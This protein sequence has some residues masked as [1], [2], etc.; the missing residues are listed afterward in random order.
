M[1]KNVKYKSAFNE[2]KQVIDINSVIPENREAYT[3]PGCGNELIA[4]LGKKNIKHFRHK[5]ICDCNLETHLHNVAKHYFFERYNKALKNKEPVPLIQAQKLVCSAYKKVNGGVCDFGE[6][7][8]THDLTKF[9]TA[10]SLEKQHDGFVADVLLTTP[11]G[12][13]L[14]VEIAVTHKCEPKKISSGNRIIEFR[15]ESEA[16]LKLL[17]MP[18][19][20]TKQNNKIR[21]YNFQNPKPGQADCGGQCNEWQHSAILLHASGKL[22]YSL[23]SPKGALSLPNRKG[24]Q[25]YQ[26]LDKGLIIEMDRTIPGKEYMGI[27]RYALSQNLKLLTCAVCKHRRMAKW[28]NTGFWCTKVK[29]D[30]PVNAAAECGGY[31]PF[32]TVKEM[33]WYLDKGL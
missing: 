30:V 7:Q 26:L 9:F 31:T 6:T 15:L 32:K 16:D 29:T 3:C 12:D 18:L 27:A 19:D 23:L 11:K 5:E 25:T 2:A 1:T 20:T 17:D 33:D 10:C 4:V 14:F 8:V 24:L 22:Q 21:F 28:A 13:A